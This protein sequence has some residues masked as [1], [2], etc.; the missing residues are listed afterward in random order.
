MSKCTHFSRFFG[1]GCD[2]CKENCCSKCE[3][4]CRECHR[5]CCGKC[6]DGNNKCHSCSQGMTSDHF[7]M[8]TINWERCDCGNICLPVDYKKIKTEPY[9]E[10]DHADCCI[11]ICCGLL[12]PNTS[13]TNT[14]I[15]NM[16]SVKYHHYEARYYCMKCNSDF[17]K[18]IKQPRILCF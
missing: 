2:F 16:G 10:L 11:G 8:K 17:F 13:T 5:F 18:I 1:I 4:K 6:N 12:C 14:G 15:D 9:D 7:K 3:V